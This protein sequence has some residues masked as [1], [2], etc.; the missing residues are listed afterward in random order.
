MHLLLQAMIGFGMFFIV[1]AIWVGILLFGIVVNLADKLTD[2]EVKRKRI[3]RKLITI[4]IIVAMITWLIISIE[5]TD[6]LIN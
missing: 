4:I 2:K 5:N 1:C 3:R 6:P